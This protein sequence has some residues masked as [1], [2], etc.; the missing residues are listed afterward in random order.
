[1]WSAETPRPTIIPPNTP[2]W[3]D[4]IPNTSVVD[5]FSMLSAPPW[6][7]IIALTAACI[8]KNAKAPDNAA[9]SFSCFAIPIATPIANIIG[10]FVN[11]T[12]PAAFKTVNIL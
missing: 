10:K 1:M 5:P 2:I 9:T 7:A 4:V 12:F 6:T 3:R 8:M 11:T